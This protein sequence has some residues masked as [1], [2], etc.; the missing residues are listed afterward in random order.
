MPQGRPIKGQTVCP[1]DN[2]I[3]RKS[4]LASRSHAKIDNVVVV[5]KMGRGVARKRE[6][7]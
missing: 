3:V 7:R 4:P 2:K 6:A 1:G 5:W